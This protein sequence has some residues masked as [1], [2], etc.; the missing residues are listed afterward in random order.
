MW[1]GRKRKRREGK[2]EE[3][4]GEE[5]QG[6]GERGDKLFLA[7]GCFINCHSLGFKEKNEIQTGLSTMMFLDLEII[8][9]YYYI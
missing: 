2:G 9:C 6:E 5:E 8:I 3:E 4:E 7:E 1:M